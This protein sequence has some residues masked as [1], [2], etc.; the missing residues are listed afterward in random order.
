VN[1]NGFALA[2]TARLS[3]K[4]QEDPLTLQNERTSII[5]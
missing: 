4:V 1:K 3:P 5:H 2:L